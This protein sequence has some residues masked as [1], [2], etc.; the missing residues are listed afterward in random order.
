MLVINL[1]AGAFL[2]ERARLAHPWPL[3]APTWTPPLSVTCQREP[4][5]TFFSCFVSCASVYSEHGTAGERGAVAGVSGCWRAEG[6]L[7]G[8]RSPFSWLGV[9]CLSRHKGSMNRLC[10][11][12]SFGVGYSMY[13]FVRVVLICKI[14][15]KRCFCLG[16]S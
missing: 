14:K 5:L 7:N 10:L 8:A 3:R 16:P 15:L 12:S 2:S 1:L 11:A 4:F 13:E 6:G 9:T